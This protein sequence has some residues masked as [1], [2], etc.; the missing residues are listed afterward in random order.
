M[1][2]GKAKVSEIDRL[3]WYGGCLFCYLIKE[4]VRLIT[5]RSFDAFQ[6]R[7]GLIMEIRLRNENSCLFG[8][9]QLL[10]QEKFNSNS[11]GMQDGIRWE[12]VAD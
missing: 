9:T 12:D 5:V 11:D 6:C 3:E 10:K 7:K 1:G 2:K 4:E 8:N